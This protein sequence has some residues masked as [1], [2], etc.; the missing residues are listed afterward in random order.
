MNRKRRNLIAIIVMITALMA[1]VFGFVANATVPAHPGIADQTTPRMIT[2]WKYTLDNLADAGD[3]G[4][5]TYV[6]AL[7]RP[8]GAVG[9]GGVQFQIQR[10]IPNPGVA[11]V[12]ARTDTGWTLCPNFTTQII[13]T[14]STAPYVGR[15][16]IDLGSPQ[17]PAAFIT[18][19]GATPDGIYL[20]TELAHPDIVRPV[21]PFF[22]HM[23]Q[24]R[25]A[26]TGALESLIYHVVVQPKNVE[27]QSLNPEKTINEATHNTHISGNNFRWELQADIPTD[28]TTRVPE[29][30]YLTRTVRCPTTGFL[31]EQT[32]QVVANQRIYADFFEIRDVLDPR[33]NLLTAAT[34]PTP[35]AADLPRMQ[36]RMPGATAGTF[37]PWVDLGAANFTVTINPTNPNDITFALTNT[38]K[39]YISDTG[40]AQ[41][42]ALIT[43]NV[44]V[45]F[46]G[47]IDNTF[48]VQYNGPDWRQ[49]LVY[50]PG[51]PN[52][53]QRRRPQA[54][55]SPELL[56]IYY[57]GGFVIRKVGPV[58]NAP[59]AGAVFRIATCVWAT[60]AI[61]NR[62]GTEP[63]TTGLANAQ[64]GRFL[65][66]NGNHYTEAELPTGV[67]FL[68][69]TSDAQG[70]V[71]FNGL[72]L[73][74]HLV[75]GGFEPPV[76]DANHELLN[77]NYYLVEITA[78]V[79]YELLRAP[80]QVTVNTRTH[81]EANHF[82]MGP[83]VNQR[84]TDLPF[85]GG[86]GTVLIVIIAMSVI[87][88]SVVIYAIDKKRRRG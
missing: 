9:F 75:G 54:P 15:A 71:A 35:A 58:A 56:P 50:P 62:V 26:E 8:E 49:P 87:G 57:T 7:D 73:A 41:I 11:L 72:P 13:T 10:V 12:D 16:Q 59:L 88:L 51:D 74:P 22:V 79:G 64:A 45:G 19:V 52:A 38:G 5:G 77:R 17:T 65:A 20:I 27:L 63:T 48:T 61:G 68:Q 86:M 80:F 30:G 39:A 69:T 67:T 46:N 33:L 29:A 2:I 53:G 31:E 83:I 47:V 25:R 32:I 23:P 60:D 81:L 28:L 3:R 37:G 78:P 34:D 55:E 6:G 4:D 18:G 43:T 84:I 14:S 44:D 66:S 1:P 82:A 36:V 76:T 42:R 85:T 40:Y 70:V 21:D 24:T